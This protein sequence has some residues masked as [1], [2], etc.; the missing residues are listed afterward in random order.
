MLRP[1]HRDTAIVSDI[2][3]QLLPLPCSRLIEMD[4]S[5][6]IVSGL[7]TSTLC[8]VGNH[9][10]IYSG[11]VRTEVPSQDQSPSLGF[12]RFPAFLSCTSL[13]SNCCLWSSSRPRGHACCTA[14][15]L[16]VETDA[17]C[18]TK[19]GGTKIQWRVDVGYSTRFSPL[20][21][22]GRGVTGAR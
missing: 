6:K 2:L 14:V 21:T 17:G 12:L 18:Q 20:E 10:A 3:L 8:S 7:L 16:K 4:P 15:A 11:L 22:V 1:F 19:R 9:P 13:V 5:R